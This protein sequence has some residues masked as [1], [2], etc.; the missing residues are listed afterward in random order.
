MIYSFGDCELDVDRRVLTRLGQARHVEP[1]VFDLLVTLAASDGAVVSHDQLIAEVWNGLNISD[2]TISARISA[3]RA[4]VGD[5]GKQQAVIRTVVRRGF[6]LVVPVT[7]GQASE[8]APV[9][10]TALRQE[11]RMTTAPDGLPLAY[12]RSGQGPPL[13]RAAHWLSH[14]ELDTESPTW[15]PFFDAIGQDHTL[16]RYDPRGTGLSG[17]QIGDGGIDLFVSDLLAVVDA[18]GIDRFPILAPS[19]AAPVALRFAARYPERV[20]RIVSIGGYAV[21]RALREPNGDEVDE[22]TI[23][24]LVRAGWGQHGSTFV[25]SFSSL[26]MP[27]GTPEQIAHFVEVQRASATPE[28]AVQMRM[29]IDRF[30]IRQDLPNVQAPVLLLHARGDVIHPLSQ[31]QM[32]AGTLPNARVVSLNSNNHVPLPHSECWPV[33]MAEI[34]AFLAEG[35]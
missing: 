17:R 30:D 5:S 24:A 6:Q 4:A 23:L 13:V 1:Q 12:A 33:M 21:G 11:I 26:F 14:L 16:V 15:R 29:A 18:A 31:S 8:A 10:N 3:A 34:Q 20:S 7:T 22:P 9:S 2:A 19:Q 27:D 35:S 28:G 25:K 32:M